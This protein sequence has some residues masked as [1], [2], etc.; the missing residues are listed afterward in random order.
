MGKQTEGLHHF[1]KY[2]TVQAEGGECGRV[3]SRTA[4]AAEIKWP[5]GHISLVPQFDPHYTVIRRGH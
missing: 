5:D 3:I 4:L 1:N 2:D